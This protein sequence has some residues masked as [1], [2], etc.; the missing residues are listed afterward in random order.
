MDKVGRE[1]PHAKLVFV[2]DFEYRETLEKMAASRD[3]LTG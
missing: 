3:T 2:G 1:R